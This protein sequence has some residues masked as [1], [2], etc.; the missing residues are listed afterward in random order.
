MPTVAP[1]RCHGIIAGGRAVAGDFP[2]HRRGR[3]IQFSGNGPKTQPFQTAPVN[4]VTF[5]HGQMFVARFHDNTLPKV[6][7][8]TSSPVAVSTSN[9]DAIF[10]VRMEEAQSRI[11]K[12]NPEE[13]E[14]QK[15]F[16]SEVGARLSDVFGSDNIFWVEGQTEELCFPLI[17][18]EVL[19]RPLL[20]TTILGVITTGDLENKHATKVYE[21]YDRL[22]K[23]KGLLPPAIGFFF[24][25]EGRS[26]QDRRDLQ[27][28]SQNTVA[29]TKRRM[30]ENY[31]LNSSAIAFVLD[32]HF[33]FTS[34]DELK[35][36]VEEWLEKNKRDQRYLS[37][38]SE[39]SHDDEY[40][41][42]N[43]H[44]ARLISDIFDAMTD[45]KLRYDKVKHG[46]MLTEWIACNARGN[47]QGLA[48]EINDLLDRGRQG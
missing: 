13:A 48:D 24:D 28:R 29:F 27:R 15:L 18:K 43:V 11:D 46:V 26:E 1:L 36:K 5:F 30:Y 35:G 10:L 31:L 4:D 17:M 34:E 22:C 8:C 40:W 2:R 9:P 21:I 41:L 7:C 6:R 47:L 44:G 42:E 37:K 14:Q 3:T 38:G 33:E 19:K 39:P 16:L 12:I 32:S 20:G 45:G 25:R 23:G